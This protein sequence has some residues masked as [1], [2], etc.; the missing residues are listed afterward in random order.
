MPCNSIEMVVVKTFFDQRGMGCT[1]IQSGIVI[2]TTKCKGQKCFL[3]RTLFFHIRSGE[4]MADQIIGQDFF[5][6]KFNRSI[7]CGGAANSI[8]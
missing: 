7:Y 3:F 1:H 6:K 4:E 2:G 8:E 5:V